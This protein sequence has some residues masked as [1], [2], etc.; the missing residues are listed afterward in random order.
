MPAERHWMCNWLVDYR[1]N[2]T[3]S[4]E[5]RHVAEWHTLR[6]QLEWLQKTCHAYRA[7]IGCMTD[8]ERLCHENKSHAQ[9]IENEMWCSNVNKVSSSIIIII[10]IILIVIT[11]IIIICLI[12][13]K[14]IL[15]LHII[16]ILLL[17]ITIIKII[18]LIIS[19]I[20]SSSKV[21]LLPSSWTS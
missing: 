18:Y 17:I 21:T 9:L 19:S 6:G 2:S 14:I 16:I 15:L 7:P 13:I 1:H 5:Q 12:I 11:Y 8:G 20:K 10:I 3:T 4:T